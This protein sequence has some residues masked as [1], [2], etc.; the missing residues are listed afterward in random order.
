MKNGDDQDTCGNP[1]V[2]SFAHFPNYPFTNFLR[3]SD[4]GGDFLGYEGLD[5]I[6]S[7][8]VIEISDRNAAFHAV[9]DFAG[10]V[11]ETLQRTDFA[12][13]NLDAIAHQ[14]HIRIAF[15]QAI[16]HV[17]TG[18]GADLGH[19]EGLT[20]FSTSQVSLL[21][22]WLKQAGHGFPDLILQLVNDGVQANIHVLHFGELLR[23]ALRTHVEADNH[24]IGS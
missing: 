5:Y 12:F 20:H 3:D 23:F 16:H 14:A 13:V 6:A 18:N 4:F 10:I 15:N 22:D 8:Y 24:R 2:R 11:F 7:L 17:T 21:D 9:S 19:A 1:R